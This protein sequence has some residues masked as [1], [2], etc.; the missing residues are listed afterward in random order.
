[1]KE[2]YDKVIAAYKSGDENAMNAAARNWV[3]SCPDNPFEPGTEANNLYFE[4]CRNYRL[5]KGNGISSRVSKVRMINRVKSIAA[6]DLPNPYD[7]PKKKVKKEEPV[8]VLGIIPEE[9]VEP[10]VEPVV[11]SA[12]EIEPLEKSEP[13]TIPVPQVSREPEDEKKGFFSKRKKRQ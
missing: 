3:E 5:W 12:V 8:H 2:L 10:A 6:L 1:M 13:E 4:A 11:E 9:K 7:K